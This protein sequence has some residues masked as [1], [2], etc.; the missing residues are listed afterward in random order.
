MSLS[1]LAGQ[2]GVVGAIA[3]VVL[4]FGA[5]I[6]VHE[7]GHFLA[8]RRV[9]LIVPRFSIGFG[10]K[11]FGWTR[12]GTEYR[13]SLLP[14]GG[15]VALPQLADMSDI[16]GEA[17]DLPP[18]PPLRF[19]DKFTV[20]VAG[21]VCNVLFAFVLAVVVWIIG[22]PT[23]SRRETTVIGWVASTLGEAAPGEA[24]HPSPAAAAGLLPGDRIVRIDGRPVRDF[25]DVTTAIVA[26][27][28][29]NDA[30]EPLSTFI[31][32]RGGS[33][34][35]VD[36]LPRIDGPDRLRRVGISP[37]DELVIDRVLPNSPA[38]LAGLQSGD[39][40]ATLD[41]VPFLS[42]AAW[43]DAIRSGAP[44]AVEVKRE[45]EPSFIVNL[46]AVDAVVT[47]DG[48]VQP[49]AGVVFG[50]VREI[51]R[52][53]VPP[54]TR[55]ADDAGLIVRFLQVLLHRG[56]DVGLQQMSGPV[57]IL[58][59]LYQAARFDIAS[60]LALAILI[61]V[62]LAI[63]NLLP[64]PVLDGGQIV[65]AAI[66]RLRGRPLPPNLIAGFQSAFVL[67]FL[68]LMAYVTIFDVR[69][70]GRDIRDERGFRERA[71]RAIEPVFRP[72]ELS[73]PSA[74]SDPSDIPAP[75]TP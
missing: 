73:D 74:R 55:I 4:L 34:F 49:E 27:T 72:S 5:S 25:G 66:A 75:S 35:E 28:R 45:D 6:F 12:G 52:K 62:N 53:H 23:A 40:I 63:F 68:S 46:A 38:E 41:G 11:L 33:E 9:G 20:L 18:A 61:N 47:S 26:G 32:E 71:S 3:L 24:A 2:V 54:H 37:A 21:A 31:V 29:R 39:R 59:V 60:F 58:S 14:L 64:L 16:E 69:R 8:A 17:K 19:R 10:P 70:A 51:W 15:Y 65:F 42:W 43:R 22:E 44:F 7:L 48:Q 56:S 1:E 30:G 57:G 36:V 67:L 50:Q 13:I